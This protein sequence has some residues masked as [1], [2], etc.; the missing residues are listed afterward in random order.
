[1]TVKHKDFLGQELKLGDSVII[2]LPNYREHTRSVVI[3]FTP[4][5]VR[6]EYQYQGYTCTYLC[7]PRDVVLIVDT[8]VILL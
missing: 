7:R 5:Q 4:Q 3:Q 2:M 6:V 8:E 1:M